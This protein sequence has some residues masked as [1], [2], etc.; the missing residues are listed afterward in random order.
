MSNSFKLVL[1]LG[2]I[3]TLIGLS[4]CNQSDSPEQRIEAAR[5][6][7][8][9]TSVNTIV[10]GGIAEYAGSLPM[11]Q[12]A[13]AVEKLRSAIRPDSVEKIAI[14]ALVKTFTTEELNALTEFYGS[15]V[16]K[17]AVNKFGA[18]SA[19]VMPNIRKEIQRAA[20]SGRSGM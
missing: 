14:D 19:E 16:G 5:Q 1:H 8:R 10:D 3:L 20:A 6:Y 18:Y 7:L 13:S 4:A 9:V 2:F 11:D 17:R 12:R 15:D